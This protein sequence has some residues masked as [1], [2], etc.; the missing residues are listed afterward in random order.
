M[1]TQEDLVPH[2]GKNADEKKSESGDDEQPNH[3]DDKN[4]DFGSSNTDGKG[5]EEICDKVTVETASITNDSPPQATF[6][7]KRKN[8]GDSQRNLQPCRKRRRKCPTKDSILIDVPMNVTADLGV[9]LRR[10]RRKR[11]RRIRKWMSNVMASRS[12]ENTTNKVMKSLENGNNFPECE[13]SNGAVEDADGKKPSN[14]TT[15]AENPVNEVMLDEESEDGMPKR[16]QYGSVIDYLEA[17]YV[18]GVMIA[19]YDERERAR[20]K[21][22]ER[23]KGGNGEEGAV[24]STE[25]DDSDDDG[26]GSCYEDDD[27]DFLDDSLLH[28]EVADQVLASSSYGKTR[29][30]EEASKRK[31]RKKDK[32]SDGDKRGLNVHGNETDCDERLKN[33]SDDGVDSDFDDGFFVNV[34]ELEMAEGWS[35]DEEVVIAPSKKAKKGKGYGGEKTGRPKSS[36]NQFKM[37]DND[38]VIVHPDKKKQAQP[39]KDKTTISAI[40]IK[41]KYAKM[42]NS[43]KSSGK[44]KQTNKEAKAKATSTCDPEKKQRKK[45]G[46]KQ[47]LKPEE[48]ITSHSKKTKI[49]NTPT[50]KKVAKTTPVRS[51]KHKSPKLLPK[52]EAL[53]EKVA[54]LK[55]LTNRKYNL[56]VKMIN[57]LTSEE[58]PTKQKNKNLVKVSV[59]IPPDSSVGDEITFENPKVPG[60]KL[61]VRIPKKADFKK[62]CF[63]V[64]V[65]APKV[66]DDEKQEK[67]ENN[68]PREL[69]EALFDYSNAYDNWTDAEYEYQE[70]LPEDKTKEKFRPNVHKLKKFDEMIKEFP[71]KILTPIDVS[72][73]RLIVRRVR[74][75]KA[76]IQARKEGSYFEARRGGKKEVPD[77]VNKTALMIRIPQKGTQFSLISFN[78]DDFEEDLDL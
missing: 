4:M 38:E 14:A 42:N 67:K 43:D 54:R 78:Y 56:C 6:D 25:G 29:I 39:Q 1:N 3:K 58:L 60:Q 53:K 30:E 19:D 9:A 68:L 45:S 50:P 12:E 66:N 24:N 48:N 69:K 51:K 13:T 16:E 61:K 52:P 35:G 65:P 11:V 46:P 57:D 2:D 10:T 63:I 49:V 5:R 73:L 27:G 8:I 34:G 36:K 15:K 76:K 72:Y 21:K 17:K 59:N 31:R 47:N 77:E 62:R 44:S 64:S 20:Q 37:D 7:N 40:N 71:Q 74:N 70:T 33:L 55:K 28:E 18:R 32:S 75:N 22:K 41:K 26:K 23:K